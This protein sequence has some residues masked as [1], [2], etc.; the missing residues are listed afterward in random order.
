MFWRV[1]LPNMRLAFFSAA[2]KNICAVRGQR[3]NLEFEISNLKS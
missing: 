1:S 2:S 3:R